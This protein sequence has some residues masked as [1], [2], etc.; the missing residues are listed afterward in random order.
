MSDSPSDSAR[1]GE[2]PDQDA[3]LD[4]LRWLQ[5]TRQKRLDAMQ[6]TLQQER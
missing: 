6:R 1:D 2:P 4:N 5:E 3:V